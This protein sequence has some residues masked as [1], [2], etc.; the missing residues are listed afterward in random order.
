[1]T[2]G[3]GSSG[4]G[5]CVMDWIELTQDRDRF[6]GTVVCGMNFRVP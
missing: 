4:S 5:I 3:Y 2:I 1:V 6:V